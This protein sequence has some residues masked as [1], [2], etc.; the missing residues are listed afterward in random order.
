MYK[1]SYRSSAT[2][3]TIQNRCSYIIWPATHSGVVI[4]D[5]GFALPPGG[6]IQ[7]QAPPGCEEPPVILAK[8]SLAVKDFYDVS[9]VDGYNVGVG[10]QPTGG[11]GDCCYAACARDVIGSFPK[12][13]Q[14]VS[15]GGGTVVA[16]K[17][18]CTCGLTAYSLLFK[19][20]WLSAYSYAY[21]DRSSTFT[22]SGSDYSITFCAN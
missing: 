2:E 11:S 17:S 4:A 13:L 14:L 10:V 7:F 22:C 3:F 9:L 20:L 1:S 5:G 18:A 15:S 19:G 16:C 12:E 6:T 8:F 21:D